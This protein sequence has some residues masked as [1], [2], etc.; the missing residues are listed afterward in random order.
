[1]KSTLSN[2]YL[3]VAI[4]TVFENS[5]NAIDA[6]KLLDEIQ[7]TDEA[8]PFV[9]FKDDKNVFHMPKKLEKVVAQDGK[10]I[11]G[12]EFITK[13]PSKQMFFCPHENANEECLV[14]QRFEGTQRLRCASE[15][16]PIMQPEL[17]SEQCGVAGAGNSYISVYKV[18]SVD[19]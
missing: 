8:L 1:M 10:M 3:L 18:N 19:D 11:N 12:T 4:E 2:D 16:K 7:S 17:N 15:P 9:L 5:I 14:Y 13:N 6:A